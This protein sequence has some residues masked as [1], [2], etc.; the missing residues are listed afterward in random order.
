MKQRIS[1]LDQEDIIVAIYE[2]L[3]QGLGNSTIA[4]IISDKFKIS[5]SEASIRRF[6]KRHKIEPLDKEKIQIENDEIQIS[7]KVN[8]DL[9]DPEQMLKERG[10]DP[11]DWILDSATVNQWTGPSEFGVQTHHQAKLHIKRKKDIN[12]V[13]PARSEGWKAPKGNFKSTSD[14]KLVVITADHHCPF[15]DPRLHQTFLRWLEENYPDEGI[16]LGDLIDAPDISRHRL[17]PENNASINEC[18]QSAYQVLLD[19]KAT[20]PNVHWKY[21]LGNHCAR[22]R[23]YLIDNARELYGIK[24]ADERFSVLDLPYL[25]RLDE[26][27]IEFV[28][29]HGEYDAALINCGGKLALKHGSKANGGAGNTALKLLEQYDHSIVTAHVHR[30]AIV[31]K[32]KHDIDGKPSTL[33]AAE[34]GCMASIDK[35][36]DFQGRRYPAYLE[37]ADWQNGFL[38]AWIWPD[39]IFKLDCATY[40]DGILLWRDQRYEL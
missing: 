19:Y 4:E 38:T 33:V 25:L 40:F 15:Y 13:L 16:V 1:P 29:P 6:R 17:D 22:I 26:L 35:R 36:N 28:D 37:K 11:K 7:T 14:P 32:T 34:V 24:R 39:G 23:N 27:D 8:C 10:L 20:A 12:L 2:L 21:A 31:H 3:N 30:Q 9:A 5:C 18:I